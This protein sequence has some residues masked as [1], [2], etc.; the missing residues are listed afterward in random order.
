[1]GLYAQQR[2][3]RTMVKREG[4]MNW[5][6]W[7]LLQITRDQEQNRSWLGTKMQADTKDRSNFHWEERE[8]DGEVK[9]FGIL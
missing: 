9:V 6:M 5:K 1:M 2:E 8:F 4:R 7:F 3:G